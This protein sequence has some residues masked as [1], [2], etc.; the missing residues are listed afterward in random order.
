MLCVHGSNILTLTTTQGC[1]FS[2]SLRLKLGDLRWFAV[3]CGIN[4]YIFGSLIIYLSSFAL[5]GIGIGGV[6]RAAISVT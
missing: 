1:A 3:V 4:A 2:A 5:V 6:T